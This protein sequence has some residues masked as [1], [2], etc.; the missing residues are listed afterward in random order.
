MRVL[1]TTQPAAGSFNPLVPFARALA[2]AGHAVAV[3]CADAFRPDV[4][5]AGFAT[6]AAGLDGRGDALPRAFPDA[7]PPGSARAGWI[8]RHWRYTTARAAVPD[9]LALAA[10]GRPDLLVREGLEFGA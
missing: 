8:A 1:F 7:P 3:A 6:F 5:A 9:L 10:R 2:D 4:E